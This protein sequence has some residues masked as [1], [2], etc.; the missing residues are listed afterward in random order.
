MLAGRPIFTMPEAGALATSRK[1][2]VYGINPGDSPSKNYLDA[3]AVQFRTVIDSTGGAYFGLADP[4][5]IPEIVGKITAE[6]SKV[7]KGIPQLVSSDI[8]EVPFYALFLSVCALFVA[9]WRLR[10]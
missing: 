6:Q 9:S 10:R 4:A 8:P 1:I 7:L 5:A 2:R 3:L